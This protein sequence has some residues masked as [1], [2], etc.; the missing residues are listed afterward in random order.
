MVIWILLILHKAGIVEHVLHVG[1]SSSNVSTDTYTAVRRS[2]LERIQPS[3]RQ[4]HMAQDIMVRK[5]PLT[6]K[7]FFVGWEVE[8]VIVTEQK[9]AQIRLFTILKLPKRPLYIWHAVDLFRSCPEK[10]HFVHMGEDHMIPV[11]YKVGGDHKS[12]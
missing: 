8:P 4:E 3:T 10:N 1:I 5:L 9:A 12:H 6:I 11:P 7:V 2:H